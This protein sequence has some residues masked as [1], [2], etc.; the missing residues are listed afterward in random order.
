MRNDG[1]ITTQKRLIKA[2]NGLMV[3]PKI[4]KENTFD[5]VGADPVLSTPK[6][7]VTDLQRVQA[8]GVEQDNLGNWVEAWL[9]VDKFSDYTDEN[10]VLV[11][12]AEQETAFLDGK[13]SNDLDGCYNMVNTIRANKEQ[14]VIPITISSGTFN[15]RCSEDNVIKLFLRYQAIQSG[16]TTCPTYWRD[17]DNNNNPVVANDFLLMSAAMDAYLLAI[18]AESHRY[19]DLLLPAATTKTEMDQLCSDFEAYDPLVV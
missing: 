15:Y 7:E 5:A 8:N 3:L 17:E 9:V 18:G 19:K 2:L 13:L 1:S 14:S 4:W 10:D 16:A 11:T 6:P 12:K